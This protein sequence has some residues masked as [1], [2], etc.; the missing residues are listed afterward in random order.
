MDR[1]NWRTTVHRI[2]KELGTTYGISNNYNNIT[3]PSQSLSGHL[4]MQRGLM[5]CSAWGCREAD[6]TG[7]ARARHGA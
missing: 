6:T 3:C 2:A 5:G 1:E 4:Q 7:H